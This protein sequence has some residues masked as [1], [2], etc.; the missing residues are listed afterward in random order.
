MSRAVRPPSAAEVRRWPVTVGVVD[1][2]RCWGLGRDQSYDLARLGEF[3]VPVLRLG[4]RL[5]VTR[6]ALLAALGIADPDM[7]LTPAVSPDVPGSA[8]ESDSDADGHR[9]AA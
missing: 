1:A 2:G 5:V 6:A 4:A 3:P 8:S 9:G 7:S